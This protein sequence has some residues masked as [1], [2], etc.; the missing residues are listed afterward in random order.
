MTPS[1]YEIAHI[2]ETL[3][4]FSEME[5]EN[6][7]KSRAYTRAARE[8]KR[9]DISLAELV[10]RGEDLTKYP[11]IGKA[12][13]KKIREIVITGRLEKLEELKKKYPPSLIEL[14]TIPGLGPKKLIELHRKLGIEG[15]EDL[16]NLLKKQNTPKIPGIGPKLQQKILSYLE[17]HLGEKREY[18]F[19]EAEVVA[20]D[21][22]ELFY[23]IGHRAIHI[24]GSVRRKKET[25]SDVDVLVAGIS[26]SS[27]KEK[28]NKKIPN[29]TIVEDRSSNRIIFQHGLGINVDIRLVKGDCWGEEVLRYTGDRDFTD[30]FFNI[31]PEGNS[32]V[33]TEE[34][35]FSL[36]NIPYIPP[37]LREGKD[38]IERAK[39][40]KIPSLIT[41]SS[42]KGDLHMHSQWTDGRNSIEEMALA[43]KKMGYEYI[44]IT[45]HSKRMR[46]VRGLDEKRLIKQMEEIDTLNNKIEG[47]RILKGIEVDILEDGSLDLSLE[48]LERL[49]YVIASV[50]SH[51]SLSRKKQTMRIIRAL[52][53]DVV[54]ILGH[55]SGR[56]LGKRPPME[57]DMEE[58]LKVARE[59]GCIMEL[60]SQPDRLDLNDRYLKKAK[61]MGIK[62]AINS[63]AHHALGLGV[64]RFGINQ[65]RRGWLE[66]EDVINT[67]S[68]EEILP[69]LKKAL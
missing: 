57:I 37:E 35:L 31:Y 53:L 59:K 22:K 1:N 61:E 68:L 11:A 39:Q 2:L 28:I 21:I 63:D 17:K 34:E 50:H 47:I 44:G 69:L 58:V 14:S 16:W 67:L 12:I 13:E 55:P 25:V 56:L 7:H 19:S 9:L 51:F 66:P 6:P 52:S 45:D 60:N 36:A 48:V 29:L 64:M 23:T 62:I 43:A 10:E 3:A 4:F 54:S 30:E 33:S 27:L 32:K 38:I 26:K 41:L 49:D 18:K 65:A 15:P 20:Q 40:G 46:M 24:V 42:I 5:G 8:I